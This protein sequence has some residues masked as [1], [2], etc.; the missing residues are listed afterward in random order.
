MEWDNANWNLQARKMPKAPT[1]KNLGERKWGRLDWDF[2]AQSQ[3]GLD[4]DLSEK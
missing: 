2:C 1:P 4:W 3:G